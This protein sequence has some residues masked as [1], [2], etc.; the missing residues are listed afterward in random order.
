VETDLERMIREAREGVEEL[1][2]LSERVKAEQTALHKVIL[3]GLRV[4]SS[5]IERNMRANADIFEAR[6]SEGERKLRLELDEAYRQYLN[7]LK[8]LLQFPPR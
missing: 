8:K 5:L 3:D 6:L 1:R 7:L 4:T 2:S